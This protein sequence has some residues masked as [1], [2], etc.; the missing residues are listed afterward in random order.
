MRTMGQLKSWKALLGQGGF[1]SEDEPPEYADNGDNL[2][3][4]ENELPEYASNGTW[5]GITVTEGV[6]SEE[7]QSE[8][9][10]DIMENGAVD[11]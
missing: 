1:R 9:L 3:R 5:E 6:R 7:E 4:S 8:C 11:R 2:F 10:L